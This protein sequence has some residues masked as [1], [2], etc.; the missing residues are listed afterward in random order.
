MII[1]GRMVRITITKIIH[2]QEIIEAEII[3]AL[4]TTEAETA[5]TQEDLR[6]DLGSIREIHL[7]HHGKDEATLN[8]PET[9][10]KGLIPADEMT[11]A[12]IKDLTPVKERSEAAIADPSLV[13][14]MVEAERTGPTHAGEITE[15]EIKDPIHKDVIGDIEIKDLTL[16]KEE[17]GIEAEETAE[18]I[19]GG[20]EIADLPTET[21]KEMGSVREDT[22]K[23]SITFTT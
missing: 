20:Q 4:A 11:E 19:I 5:L 16:E 23:I 21:M 2:T 9:E 22:Q 7:D 3:E 1:I 17:A 18:T 6:T 8:H 12:E 13:T 15:E 14:E 10:I